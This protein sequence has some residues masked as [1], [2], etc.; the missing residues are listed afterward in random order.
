MPEKGL[1]TRTYSA[2][3]QVPDC[4]DITRAKNKLPS[5]D[6]YFRHRPS[7]SSPSCERWKAQLKNLDNKAVLQAI[8]ADL[9]SITR[10]VSGDLGITQ[11]TFITLAKVSEATELCPM[12]PMHLNEYR[13][14]RNLKKN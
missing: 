2:R 12:F 7:K 6:K 11:S 3:D 8:E 4:S 10:R 13:R 14:K 5:R 1:L 9:G